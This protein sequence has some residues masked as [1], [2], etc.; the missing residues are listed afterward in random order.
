MKTK[1]ENIGLE[2]SCNGNGQAVYYLGPWRT[3][4][5]FVFERGKTT[6]RERNGLPKR[7]FT[8]KDS[9][10]HNINFLNLA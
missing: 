9:P 7:S 10:N 6:G 2:V 3:S 5:P 1:L 4:G 8:Q